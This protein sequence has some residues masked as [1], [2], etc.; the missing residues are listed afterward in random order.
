M[1]FVYICSFVLSLFFIEPVFAQYQGSAV[2]VGESLSFGFEGNSSFTKHYDPAS[3]GQY[4]PY[5]AG[6]GFV[7][8]FEMPFSNSDVPFNFTAT[9]GITAFFSDQTIRSLLG[10]KDAYTE[11]IYYFLPLKVGAKYYLGENFYVEGEVG[12][13][14]NLSNSFKTTPTYA[15]GIGVAIPFQQIRSLDLGL[16]YETFNQVNVYNE[17]FIKGFFSLRLVYKF[18]IG[19]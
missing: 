6:I 15:P 5:Q 13:I 8:R 3:A 17:T 19:Q 14:V 10:K 12:G 4:A 1:K 9:S 2:T 18:G 11:K 16:R 7:A